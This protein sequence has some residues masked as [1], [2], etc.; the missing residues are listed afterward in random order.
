MVELSEKY[1]AWS[2]ASFTSR[3][4]PDGPFWSVACGL[5]GVTMRIPLFT[6][7]KTRCPASCDGPDALIKAA[8]VGIIVLFSLL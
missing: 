7:Q 6:A 8:P 2:G 4:Q 1:T 3:R 5:P